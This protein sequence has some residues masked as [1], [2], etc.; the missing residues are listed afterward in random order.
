MATNMDA[1]LGGGASGAASGALLGAQYGGPLG[2]LAGAGLGAITGGAGGSLTN[3]GIRKRKKAMK[4]AQN[5]YNNT[6]ASLF[7]QQQQDYAAANNQYS[8]LADQY[9][10]AFQGRVSQLPS[11]SYQTPNAPVLNAGISDPWAAAAAAEAAALRAP[12]Q[13]AQAD[14][15]RAQLQ[16]TDQQAAEQAFGLQNIDL[17][18]LL[19][20]AQTQYG[21][22]NTQRETEAQLALQRLNAALGRAQ[23]A[24]S[25]QMLYGGL[26]TSAPSIVQSFA[27]KGGIGG[28]NGQR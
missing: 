24:G 10:Q 20:L 25:E 7:A 13:Q 18:R 9:Q 21:L 3:R 4:R 17:Q 6:M 15:R 12:Q 27:G 16:N 14:W 8:S 28:I 22:R 2:A 5:D 23:D 19:Q 1:I 11:G 26:L